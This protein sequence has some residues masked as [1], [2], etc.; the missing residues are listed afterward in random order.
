VA[1]NL[2]SNGDS[3]HNA[4]VPVKGDRVS[5]VRLSQYW[6]IMT[7]ITTTFPVFGERVNKVPLCQYWMMVT[8]TVPLC[9]YWMMVT[10]IVPLS[11]YYCEN[12]VV[13]CLV[14]LRVIYELKKEALCGDHVRAFVCLSTCDLL[15]GNK[16]LV[17]YLRY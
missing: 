5:K 12:I 6:A 15:S 13:V 16:P 3:N 1:V 9:Q 7:V 4:T 8:V 14:T 2:L 11:Q 17:G 10:V